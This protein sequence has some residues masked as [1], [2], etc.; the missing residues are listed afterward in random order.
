MQ[1]YMHSFDDSV[2]L[3]R[4]LRFFNTTT[5]KFIGLIGVIF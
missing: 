5:E 2:I 4:R 3:K 1:A